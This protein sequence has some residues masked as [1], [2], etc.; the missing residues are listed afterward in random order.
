MC[1]LCNQIK[2]SDNFILPVSVKCTC[3]ERHELN[4]RLRHD[5][6]IEQNHVFE[7]EHPII[8]AKCGTE[9]SVILLP[10]E[11]DLLEGLF[12]KQ[13]LIGEENDDKIKGS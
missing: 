1:K 2:L 10:C 8:C 9:T 5:L 4:Q 12:G 7:L 11:G 6:I 13:V 3:G